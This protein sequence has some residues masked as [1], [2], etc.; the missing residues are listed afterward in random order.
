MT[1][2]QI[3]N[4]E[5]YLYKAPRLES[6]L[7]SSTTTEV[8]DGSGTLP[9]DKEF[10]LDQ[11]EA[12]VLIAL[13][14]ASASATNIEF[15][16]RTVGTLHPWYYRWYLQHFTGP[17]SQ[18][19]FIVLAAVCGTYLCLFGCLCVHCI[20]RCCRDKEEEERIKKSREVV[21]MPPIEDPWSS[22]G[23]DRE[24]GDSPRSDVRVSA[25]ASS[26][27]GALDSHVKK[28]YQEQRYKLRDYDL[29]NPPDFQGGRVSKVA[30]RS[31]LTE[32]TYELER[33]FTNPFRQEMSKKIEKYQMNMKPISGGPKQM[34]FRERR[35]HNESSAGYPSAGLEA[36]KLPDRSHTVARTGNFAS[37]D[38][39]VERKDRMR[40][41]DMLIEEL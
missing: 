18:T 17:Q 31:T 34:S 1:F 25:L 30:R 15:T 19:L 27:K 21:P 3:E 28:L 11:K 39:D 37:V 12:F 36:M 13:P 4:M 14:K 20:R 8:G 5:V 33:R 9:L 41:V 22:R 40:S 6:S 7:N 10:Q 32:N 38:T 29:Q 23:T 24:Q 16:Y 2:K 26:L 35:V